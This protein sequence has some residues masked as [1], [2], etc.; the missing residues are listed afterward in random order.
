MSLR[1]SDRGLLDASASIAVL[2]VAAILLPACG[3]KALPKP[4]EFAAP[5]TISDLRATS[6]RDGIMLAWSRPR[7]Y[8]DGS[9][10][11]ALG[12]F[13]VERHPTSASGEFVSIAT[14]EVTDRE[15]FRQTRTFRY[16]D[17]DSVLGSSYQYRVISS[18]TDGYTSAPS[19]VV[20]IER[21][22]PPENTRANSPSPTPR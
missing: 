19:N 12:Q 20:T 8:A 1:R 17:H 2:A 14:L 5:R 7:E 11:D 4:P 16:I 21:T 22:V 15:R 13:V 10:L 18:T 9:T 3:R 6:T